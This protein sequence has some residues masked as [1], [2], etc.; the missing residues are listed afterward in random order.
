MARHN[1]TGEKG[2]ELACGFLMKNNFSI[3]HK[4]WRYSYWE[5]DIIAVREN[6]LHF[7]EVKTRRT[8]EYG[9]PEENVTNKKIRN[10]INAAEGY[11]AAFPQW[12]RIQY[13]VLSIT[14]LTDSPPVFYFIEDIFL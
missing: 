2:E 8:R 1:K 11:L 6:V 10:L 13:D 4:N 3:L 14:L 7:I 12:K 5:V 9:M